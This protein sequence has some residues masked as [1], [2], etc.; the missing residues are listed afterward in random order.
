M[1]INY[2]FLKYSYSFDR[3]KPWKQLDLPGKDLIQ[4]D[5]FYCSIP[6]Q[7]LHIDAF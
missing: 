5:C 4:A 3:I 7:F 2:E 6:G 1:R